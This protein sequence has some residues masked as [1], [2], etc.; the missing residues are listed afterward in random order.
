AGQ[1]LIALGYRERGRR[2]QVVGVALYAIIIG[3]ILVAFG[4]WHDD[5]AS[6]WAWKFVTLV[7]LVGSIPFVLAG[8]SEI[9]AAFEAGAKPASPL[10]PATLGLL[11]AVAQFFAVRFV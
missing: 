6:H 8:R 3:A 10:V 11:L 9:Q 4:R 1:N 5:L 7:P 2:M